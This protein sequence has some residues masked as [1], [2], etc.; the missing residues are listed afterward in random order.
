MIGAV[1]QGGFQVHHRV[2]GQ[3]TVNHGLPH[4]LLH[5][6]EVVLGHRTAHDL[7]A[8]L[9]LLG[10]ARLKAHPH[11]A[12]L[13]VAAGL[14]LVAALHLHLLADLLAVGHPG[15]GELG[16]HA[17]AALQPGE[18]HVHLHVAGAGDH[19]LAGFGVVDPVEGQILLVQADEAGG[20]LVL[21]ALGLGGDSHGVAGLGEGDG[22]QLDHLAGIREGV[23]GLDLLHL[24]DGADV[25]ALQL[26]DLLGLL[27]LHHVQAAQLLRG[28]GAGIDQLHVGLEVAGD[29][30]HEGVLAV[31]VGD[32]LPHQGGGQGAGEGHELVHLAVGVLA[33]EGA[34][35]QGGGQQL[36]D[37]VQQHAGAQAGD[38]GAAHHGE[39]G[40]VFHALAQTLDHLGVGEVLTGKVLVHQLL[41]GLS[42]RLLE[43]IVQ[44][45]QHGL[46]VVRDVDLDALA[47][48][49]G[50]KG[51]LVEHVD[52]ADDLL[53]RVPDG[54]GHGGDILAEALPQG[55]EG[56]VVVGVLLVGLG[57]VEQP[58]QP[59]LLAQLP[60]LLRAHA[61]ARLGGADDDGRV[62]HLEGL[63]HLAGKVKVA[64]R[65]QHVDL[66]AVVLH[67]S[68]RGGDGNLTAGFLGVVIANG[69][70]VGG[71]AQP[72]GATGQIQHAL[73]QGGLT[74]STVAQQT[75]VAD[76]LYGIAHTCF[77]SLHLESSGQGSRGGRRTACCSLYIKSTGDTTEILE[78]SRK[79][80]RRSPQGGNLHAGEGEGMSAGRQA[81]GR[82]RAGRQTQCAAAE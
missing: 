60:R 50:L 5:G 2:A 17:E 7:L 30:L 11:V 36:H 68:H 38:G 39:E 66:T 71:I 27:A 14:L 33:H 69:I 4:A 70:P 15:L 75:D 47:L 28:A 72:H 74:I 35:L 12:E 9:E 64:R 1:V 8:E 73:G 16:V 45:V 3:H 42:H 63:D 61:H 58:G 44:L 24:A 65:V 46:L 25:A 49:A 79:I 67:G 18:N 37:D 48:G 34:A 31:L 77:L 51:A 82:S 41:A 81:W 59:A 43:G 23:A 20:D 40:Q 29:D 26:L 52:K 54:G 76:V 80:P 21:L 62:G 6:G 57:D 22:F 56:G 10:V 53:V 32:G 78:K 19:H 55:V 13:A